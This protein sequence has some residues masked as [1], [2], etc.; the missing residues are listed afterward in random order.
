VG[1]LKD[2]AHGV[3]VVQVLPPFGRTTV[4]VAREFRGHLAELDPSARPNYTSFEGYIA[5]RVLVEGL[6]RAGKNPSREKLVVALEGIN[7]L[8]L[9]GYIISFSSKSHDGSRF[10]DIGVVGK[11]SALVF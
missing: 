3:K 1:E 7:E 10:V 6:R 9:G 4:H 5:A 8:D 2:D 11:S